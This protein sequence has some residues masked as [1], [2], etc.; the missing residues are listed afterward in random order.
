MTNTDHRSQDNPFIAELCRLELLIEQLSV[1]QGVEPVS[2]TRLLLHLEQ[3]NLPG[4]RPVFNIDRPSEER[5][6]AR[7]NLAWEGLARAGCWPQVVR[8][9]ISAPSPL[10][11]LTIET[12]NQ[13]TQLLNTL[14]QQAGIPA[15][16]VRPVEHQIHTRQDLDG[17][18]RF[19]G[20][21][22]KVHYFKFLQ[23][24]GAMPE[25]RSLC[26]RTA[27]FYELEPVNEAVDLLCRG[28]LKGQAR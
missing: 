19:P 21:G 12:I 1:V 24:G 14:S 17:W 10:S 8:W 9:E 4:I 6:V 28:C 26:G 23:H 5:N 16:P 15:L 20:V 7:V 13:V 25:G 22:Q 27:D 11:V 2:L 18:C 3:S